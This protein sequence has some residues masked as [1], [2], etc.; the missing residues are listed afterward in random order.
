MAELSLEILQRLL[1]DLDMF[2]DGRVI[3]DT[4][5]DTFIVLLEFVYREMIALDLTATAPQL[6]LT[7]IMGFLQNALSI[8][9]LIRESRELSNSSHHLQLQV[10]LHH[11]GLVGRPCILISLEQL[12]YLIE[13]RFSVPQIADLLGVSIRTVRRRMTEFGLS[14]T[15]QYSVLSDQDLEEIV[16]RIQQQ[17]PMCGNKQMQGHLV[18]MGYRVQ[19]HR[20]RDTQRR[21]DPHG[22]VMRRLHILNRRTYSVPAPLSLYH[23]NGHHKLIRCVFLICVLYV[24]V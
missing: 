17:F 3:S 9:R 20:V 23:M 18:S 12:S 24:T 6:N 11:T 1:H 22:S 21:L 4:S 2:I 16:Q 10:P 7:S 8:A 5:L 14:I 19:Q 15:A 13:N